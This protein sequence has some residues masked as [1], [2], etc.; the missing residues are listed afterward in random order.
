MD[1]SLLYLLPA[2]VN[3]TDVNFKVEK[4]EYR[5]YLNEYGEEE[6]F[7]VELKFDV[8]TQ[9]PIISFL[10]WIE[11]LEK[12]RKSGVSTIHVY[13]K[14][15][16]MYTPENITMW[17]NFTEVHDNLLTNGYSNLSDDRKLR[18]YMYYIEEFNYYV[19]LRLLSHHDLVKTIKINNPRKKIQ[20]L[21]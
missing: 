13:V 21:I 11:T 5:S 3:E 8:N 4:Y 7:D 20:Y 10:E 18:I 15:I 1:E 19:L 14:K 16:E 17:G 9:V 12:L 6:V 2:T